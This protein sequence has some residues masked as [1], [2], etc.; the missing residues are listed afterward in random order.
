METKQYGVILAIEDMKALLE[1]T[2]TA[3]Q[4]DAIRAAVV[5]YLEQHGIESKSEKVKHGG[6]RKPG[7][8]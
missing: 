3:I 5:Y 4:S 8:S 6:H 7:A 2:E 1:S